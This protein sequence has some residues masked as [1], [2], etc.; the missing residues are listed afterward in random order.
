[1]NVHTPSTNPCKLHKHHTSLQGRN[2]KKTSD[3]WSDRLK[4]HNT[5]QTAAALS[6]VSVFIF[7]AIQC[8]R[9]YKHTRYLHF[10][11]HLPGCMT[12]CYIHEAEW[13]SLPQPEVLW[14]IRTLLTFHFIFSQEN[15]QGA[16]K[17]IYK[18]K[19]KYVNPLWWSM[20]NKYKIGRKDG[21]PQKT[22]FEWDK[23]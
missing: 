11:N 21:T 22:G 9:I 3:G 18:K 19:K 23:M 6:T 10:Y 17:Y 12:L 2:G 13:V 20:L 4:Q 14:A 5:P 1:M 15:V 8:S 7:R 16:Q